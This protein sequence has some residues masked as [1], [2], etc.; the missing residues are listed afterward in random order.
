[1]K[2]Q[3]RLQALLPGLLK[4]IPLEELPVERVQ[5]G[6]YLTRQNQGAGKIPLFLHGVHPVLIY[7]ELRKNLPFS[8]AVK[9]RLKYFI[10][11]KFLVI[12]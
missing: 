11:V 4:L 7:D 8:P 5:L 10:A 3:R 9:T 1:M 2:S 12:S 6:H